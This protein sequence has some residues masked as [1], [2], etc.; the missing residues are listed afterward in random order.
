MVRSD[1][2]SGVQPSSHRFSGYPTGYVLQMKATHPRSSAF[3]RGSQPGAF[4][5]VELLVVIG[6][7][8]ILIG[9]LLPVLAASRSTARL[10][11]CGVNQKQLGLA[12]YAYAAESNDV[13]PHNPNIALS[14]PGRGYDGPTR[15][16]NAIAL[17]EIEPPPGTGTTGLDPGLTEDTV[18]LGILIDHQLDDDRA[19]FCPDDDST[20]PVEELENLRTG[21]N[22]ASSSYYYRQLD[23]IGY[24][25]DGSG[26]FI[27]RST[28]VGQPPRLDD[29]ELNPAGL[30]AAALMLDR[31]FFDTFGGAFGGDKTNHRGAEVNILYSDG[32]VETFGNDASA[33]RPG[34]GGHFAVA[35][36]DAIPPATAP[37]FDQIFVNADFATSG[38]PADAP[39]L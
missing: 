19:A 37:R 23:A 35:A 5:L 14:N 27:Q 28:A 30:D 2:A 8:A 21:A 18:G 20:D 36:P 7:I 12:I 11:T 39:E 1:R 38:D 15:A 13:L 24:E 17:K 3:I 4:T 32:H 6:I 16:T 33:D 10:L 9:I 31:N 25:D 22:S 29:L 26:N 34:D